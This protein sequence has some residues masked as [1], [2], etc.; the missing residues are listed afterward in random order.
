MSELAKLLLTGMDV[1]IIYRYMQIF[2]EKPL[3]GKRMLVVWYI[4][5]YGIV[6]VTN[7]KVMIVLVNFI[8]SII[9]YFVA[10]LVYQSSWRK[11]LIVAVFLHISGFVADTIIAIIFGVT[12]LSLL[13]YSQSGNL[14][15]QLLTKILMWLTT[16][17][18]QRFQHLKRNSPLP[19]IFLV[20]FL[21]NAGI[22]AI[23][24]IILVQQ[25]YENQKLVAVTVLEAIIN[26]L[27]LIYQYDSFS[28][29]FQERIQRELLQREKTYYCAQLHQQEKSQQEIRRMRHDMKNHLL[30]LSG[31][32]KRGERDRAERYLVELQEILEQNFIYSKSGNTVVDSIVNY[33][34]SQATELNAVV[35]AHVVIPI[36]LDM[37]ET[38]LVVILGNLLDNA[39]E[40]LEKVEG[41]RQL[42][43]NIEYDRGGLWILIV[44]TYDGLTMQRKGKLL[45]RKKDIANHGFGLDNARE[46]A[47][48][49]GGEIEAW[50]EETEFHAELFLNLPNVI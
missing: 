29:M 36:K 31:L 16:L 46:A 26:T 10:T 21:L 3:I 32:L 17:L 28:E 27:L 7:F 41:E 37:E 8:L 24:L 44:N 23:I 11:R 19:K 35:K 33:K 39:L 2:F 20:M 4:V 49:Y 40:A 14:L 45:T 34:L 38:D 42:R 30:A 5:L 22:I 43:L 50:G 47:K 12:G 25:P 1:Y 48:K 15:A 9:I 13:G 6:A 18:V